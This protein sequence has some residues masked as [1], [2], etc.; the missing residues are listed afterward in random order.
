MGFT[1]QA[2]VETG[3]SQA[4]SLWIRALECDR[5]R[6]ALVNCCLSAII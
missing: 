1:L 3:Q 4:N 5:A 2:G 6:S